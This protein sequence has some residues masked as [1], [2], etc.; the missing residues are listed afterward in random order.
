[1]IKDLAQLAS[2][3]MRGENKTRPITLEEAVKMKIG[4]D[5]YF[6][7]KA[8]KHAR[9]QIEAIKNENPSDQPPTLGE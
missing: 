7:L 1:M 6:Q 4:C 5:V 2:L 3:T 9:E 8:T